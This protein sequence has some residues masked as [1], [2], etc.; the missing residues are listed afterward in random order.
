MW[1]ALSARTSATSQ[2]KHPAD[3]DQQ[4]VAFRMLFGDHR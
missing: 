2:Q 3:N 4:G 1:L